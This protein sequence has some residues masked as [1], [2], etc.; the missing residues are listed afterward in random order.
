MNKR[1]T[2][3]SLLDP[4]ARR[5]YTPAAF[6]LH[7]D[8]QY[9]TGQAAVEKHLEY[10]RYT[11]MDLVK[12]QYERVFPQLPAIQKPADWA[13]FPAYGLEFY[14]GQLSAVA[15]LV[16]AA[17]GEAVV[18]Q[19]LYSPYMCAGHATS[20]ELLTRHIHE[21][22]QAV[23]RGMQI[24]TES[25]ML[26][27]KECIRL[28]VDGFYTSTQGG[29]AGRMDRQLFDQCV[30]PYDLALME[31]ANRACPFNI[32]HVCDY[33]APYDEIA[34]YGDYPG[35]VVNAPLDLVNATLTPRQ[36]AGLFERPFFGGLD[37]KGVLASG[38]PAQIEAAVRATLDNAPER[39]MLGADCTIPAGVPWE[40]L[41]IAIQAAH[42]YA[43]G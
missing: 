28:G 26:F 29:D 16:Q 36:A 2:V 5:E 18:V 21:D 15:G 19:T 34:S 25:L 39:F 9:H 33:Q 13:G 43:R 37:R 20:P 23:Q 1:E 24:I 17:K 14:A 42:S 22:P 10:F 6:F 11:G 12:I 7:F 41:R 30:R 4:A 38:A 31:E 3:L 32:L 8:P 35:Q 40:N 27:V